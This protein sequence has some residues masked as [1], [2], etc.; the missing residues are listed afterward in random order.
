[1]HIPA[2]NTVAL[3]ENPLN[4][5]GQFVAKGIEVENRA[6]IH[7]HQSEFVSVTKIA[8]K[9]SP[10]IY[11]VLWDYLHLHKLIKRIRKMEIRFPSLHSEA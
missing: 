5:L 6:F 3:P 1:M 10:F 9:L 2:L 7:R 11:I 8:H 4:V